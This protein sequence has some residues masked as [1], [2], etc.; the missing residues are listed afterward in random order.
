M[1]KK[2]LEAITTEMHTEDA[3]GG[4]A[5]RYVVENLSQVEGAYSSGRYMADAFKRD[6]TL[7]E[8]ISWQPDEKERGG[9]I[10]FSTEVNAKQLHSNPVVNYL[11]Q[12]YQT[13]KNRLTANAKIN[14]LGKKYKLGGWTV[15]RGLRGR[16]LSKTGKLF[17]ESSLSLDLIGISKGKLISIAEEIC[18][19]FG[20]EEAL[21]KDYSS[22]DVFFVR[23]DVPSS[24]IGKD[25]EKSGE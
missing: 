16:Y 13:I 21:V 23:P 9:M 2:L 10:V 6:M 14:G 8:G 7:L 19:M 24:P 3:E 17:D 15:G 20:P 22:G 1:K 25:T 12:I 11:T 5:V 4:N 18:T